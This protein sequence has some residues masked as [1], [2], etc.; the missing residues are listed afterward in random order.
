MRAAAKPL[1][2]GAGSFF[3][4]QSVSMESVGSAPGLRRKMTGVVLTIEWKPLSAPDSDYKSCYEGTILKKEWTAAH[5]KIKSE[6]SRVLLRFRFD[7]GP[8]NNTGHD[9]VQIANL[10]VFT[11]NDGVL[12]VSD[13]GAR[14][15]GVFRPARPRL[16]RRCLGAH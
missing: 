10:D 5:A 3:L 11:K 9:S 15:D 13:F 12:R 2:A 16:R 4:R 6:D 1:T 7:C 8:A 14:G